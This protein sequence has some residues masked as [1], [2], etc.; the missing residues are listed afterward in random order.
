MTLAPLKI[1]P[2]GMR[3]H[4]WVFPLKSFREQHGQEIPVD[5]AYRL[6]K[7]LE[8]KQGE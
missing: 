2:T 1:A 3:L 6:M 7:E 4:E 5:A 8:R